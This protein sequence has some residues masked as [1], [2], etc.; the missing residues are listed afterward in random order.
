MPVIIKGLPG[1]SVGK[2]LPAVQETQI[3]SLGQED[4][5]GEGN[6]NTLHYYCL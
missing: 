2:E 6:G 5:P 1:S 3:R 4:S